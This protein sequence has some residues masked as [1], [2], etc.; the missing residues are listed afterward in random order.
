[1]SWYDIN[2]I[3]K[4]TRCSMCIKNYLL[5]LLSVVLL[6]L[7][8]DSLENV[9]RHIFY[10]WVFHTCCIPIRRVDRAHHRSNIENHIRRLDYTP[11]SQE[12]QL[13]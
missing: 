1:M 4:V 8:V 2:Y 7:L 5:L 11:Y 6:S 3:F 12:F 9:V 13:S 10:I